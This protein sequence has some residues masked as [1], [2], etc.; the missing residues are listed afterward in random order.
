[1][2]E[3]IKQI[4]QRV[5]ELRE[6]LEISAEDM[7][8]SLGITPEEYAKYEQPG[9]DIPISALYAIAAK[10][11]VDFTVLLTGDAPKMDGQSVVRAGTGAEVDRYEGYSFASLAYNYKGREMEP[12]LVTLALGKVPPLVCHQGQEFNYC[13]HGKVRVMVGTREHILSPGDSIYF[14]AQIPHGQSAVEGVAKFLTVLNEPYK[15]AGK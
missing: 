9:A 4:P 11:N 3:F 7:A 8:K 12:L 14:N 13:L 15:M 5:K 1:M 2:D 10:L 6:I